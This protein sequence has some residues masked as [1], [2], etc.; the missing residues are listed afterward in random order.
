MIRALF[1]PVSIATAALVTAG[2]GMPSIPLDP[3][4]VKLTG[5]WTGTGSDSQGPELITWDLTQTGNMVT[6]MVSTRAVDTTDGTCA[7]CHKNKTGT[8][9]GTISGADLTLRMFFP[10]GGDVPTPMC[11]VTMN[12][13][14]P[15][16]T[17][18]NIATSYTGLDTCEGPFAGGRFSMDHQP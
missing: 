13:T 3:P 5:T 2:C 4:T 6:G 1:V 18:Y 12:A 11:T 10:S 7:S 17:D 8:V 16:A 9:S 15:D 14:V